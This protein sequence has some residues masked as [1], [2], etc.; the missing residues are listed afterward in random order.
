MQKGYTEDVWFSHAKHT[1]QLR[2]LQGLWWLGKSAGVP[3]YDGLREEL[4]YL[5]HDTPYA[6]HTGVNRTL[7]AVQGH[8]W[9][10]GMAADVKQYVLTCR[11]CQL[12]KP[13]A[14]RAAGLLQPLPVPSKL[15]HSV[16]M[17]LITQL[18]ETPQGHSAIVDFVDRLSKMTHFAPTKNSL[19]SQGLAQL[20]IDTVV[21]LHGVPAVIVS[22]RDARLTSEFAREFYSLLSVPQ[23]MSTA[24]HPQTDGDHDEWLPDADLSNSRQK[25]QEVESAQGAGCAVAVA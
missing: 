17:D 22:D 2:S 15:W 18:P 19:D 14:R 5:F 1:E 13:E 25:V 6:G 21:R 11:K 7:K 8:Y 9:W 23:H 3:D 4:T 20:M 16:S 24:F 10:P 12:N